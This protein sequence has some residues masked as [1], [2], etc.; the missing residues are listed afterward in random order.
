[1]ELFSLE[2]RKRSYIFHYVPSLSLL[3][4]LI[5]FYV[6]AGNISEDNSS[7]EREILENAITKDITQC[8]A[9]EGVYPPNIQYLKDN[10]GLNYNENNYW[11]DYQYV[12][13][14]LRPNVTIIER[15]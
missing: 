4:L 13:S 3:L 6:V 15:E 2:N 1:M 11:I 10:Y 12:G 14:N 8:Y 7:R 5:L 9:L